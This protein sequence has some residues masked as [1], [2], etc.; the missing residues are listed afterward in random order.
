MSGQRQSDA[1]S[2]ID[3]P[4]RM[5]VGCVKATR[6]KVP[7]TKDLMPRTRR[8]SPWSFPSWGSS[9]RE[10]KTGMT[11]RETTKDAAMLVMVAIAIG[12]NRRPSIPS[13]PNKGRNT[14]MMSTVA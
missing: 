13:N 12:G 6:R 1:A 5:G 14:M 7:F 9:K 3:V 10:Q 2:K 8:P 11:V 4:T